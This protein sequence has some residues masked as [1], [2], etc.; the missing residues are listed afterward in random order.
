MPWVAIDPESKKPIIPAKAEDSKEYLCTNCGEGM[1]VRPH[2]DTE[3]NIAR[4]FTH[5]SDTGCVGETDVHFHSKMMA[6]SLLHEIFEDLHHAKVEKIDNELCFKGNGLKNQFA[7]A[8]VRFLEGI[9]P[10]GKGLAIEVQHKNKSK[11][12]GQSSQ[13]YKKKDVSVLWLQPHHLLQM[14]DDAKNWF[15]KMILGKHK[16]LKR[17]R[18]NHRRGIRGTY[19]YIV[20]FNQVSNRDEKAQKTKQ[21]KRSQKSQNIYSGDFTIDEEIFVSGYGYQYTEYKSLTP[22]TENWHCEKHGCLNH[23]V[24][25]YKYERDGLHLKIK[26]CEKHGEP[27]WA[28]ITTRFGTLRREAS[29]NRL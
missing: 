27:S 12:R 21:I 8:G 26:R 2:K 14:G 17:N 29:L 4:H 11:R 18:S 9:E 3:S 10:W 1:F 13:L 7:D 5:Y 28:E 19:P 22:E 16:N 23:F 25:V 15:Y 6:E 24:K 20:F